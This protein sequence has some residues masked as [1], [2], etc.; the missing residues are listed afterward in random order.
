MLNL[1]S[2]TLREINSQLTPRARSFFN[3]AI[4]GAI[5]KDVIFKTSAK[6]LRRIREIFQVAS[7]SRIVDRP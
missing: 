4:S 1:T 6:Q 2:E 5:A 3:D 7:A